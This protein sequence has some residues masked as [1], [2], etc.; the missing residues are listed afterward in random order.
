M[1]QRLVFRRRLSYNTKSNRRRIVRTPGGKLVYQ[2]LKKPK[3][4]P[5][6][7]QCK[8]RLRG[9]IPARSQERSRLCRRKKTV[10]R[11]YG[12]VLCHK[13]VKEKIIR[14][15]L[16]EEQ[17]IVVKVLKAQQAVGKAKK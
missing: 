11:A 2:Y 14:A 16:I 3:K 10:K 12:G 9:I 15:F 7:G 6:C 17:K 1:V 13:C 4:I 8:D 5:R